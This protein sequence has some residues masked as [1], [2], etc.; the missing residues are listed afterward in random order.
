MKDSNSLPAQPK[1]TNLSLR[2]VSTQKSSKQKSYRWLWVVTGLTGVALLSATAGAILAMTMASAP[3]LQRKLSVQDAA[4]FSKGDLSNINNL[5]LPELTRPVNV[6]VLG[7]KVLTSDVSDEPPPGQR[8]L[9]YQALVNSFEGLTDTMMLVRFNPE[10][11]KLALLSIPRD[12]RIEI[13]GHSVGKINE[14]NSVGGPALAARTVSQL[15]GGVGV[16]RYITINVQGVQALVDALGGVTVYVP[17]DMKYSDDSQHLYVNLKAGKQHLN[18]DQ[19]LQLLRFRNDENGDIGRVQRQQMVIRALSEQAL[20]PMTL[21]R[22]PQIISVIRAYIDTNLSVEEIFALVAYSS[23]VDR[24]KMEML[25]TPGEYGDIE[26]YG[27]SYWLPDLAKIQVI[28]AQHF[29]LGLNPTATSMPPSRVRVSIQGTTHQAA[30][31]W[32]NPLSKAGYSNVAIAEPYTE[33][34]DTTRILAQQGDVA[35]A[36]NIR[37]LLGFGEVR[38]DGNGDLNSDVTIQLGRDALRR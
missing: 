14:A 32:I 19:A 17:K 10:A 21:A 27:T 24:S 30:T 1:K 37:R 6:L 31:N 15:L 8:N 11:Q 23:R 22:L 25:I 38:V 35:S 26:T 18:G 13:P 9:G 7:A 12:T 4:V 3:L 16:D 2:K 33:P 5:Q 28:M 20:N 36:E 34:L 29:N